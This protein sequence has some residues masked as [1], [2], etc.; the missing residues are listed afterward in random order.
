MGVL[1]ELI[2]ETERNQHRG[3]GAFHVVTTQRFTVENCWQEDGTHGLHYA[4]VHILEDVDEASVAGAV[5]TLVQQSV[6]RIH[7]SIQIYNSVCPFPLSFHSRFGSVPA[8]PHQLSFWLFQSL[9]VDTA[10]VQVDRGMTASL[11]ES[12]SLLWR[13]G[14]GE[15]L[16]QQLV[17]RALADH[18][19]AQPPPPLPDMNPHQQTAK[20]TAAACR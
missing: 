2:T 17:S 14:V 8:S 13:L 9:A 19:R 20:Q 3:A 5:D 11:L 1:C 18:D 10:A 15:E 7:S 12:R 16:M 4:R 6:E